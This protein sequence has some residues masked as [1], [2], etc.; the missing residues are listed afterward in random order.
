M[1]SGP[2]I[3]PRV[4]VV[5]GSD[6]SGGAGVDADRD[7]LASAGV[8]ARYVVTAWTV[9]NAA[10]VRDLGL[11]DSTQWLAEARG[12]VGP[13]LGAIKFGLLPGPDALRAAAELLE[14]LAGPAWRVL[15]PVLASSS[16]TRFHDSESLCLMRQRLLPLGLVWT[17]N[18][19]ELA[20]LAAVPLAQLER[21]LEARRAAGHQLMAQGARAVV[22]KGGHGLENP[23]VDLVLGAQGEN[24]SSSRPRF[25]GA[26]IRGSGCRFASALAAHLA[27]GMALGRAVEAAGS[28]VASRLSQ[29]PKKSS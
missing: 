29:V 3:Y 12:L 10:G 4:L 24:L 16:G 11:V 23:V 14:G 8:S 15:D 7:A 27:N 13:D 17:P 18:L 22:I 26:S 19:P 21:S 1:T 6:S 28:F 25:I 9:Q 5:A 20:E 2:K